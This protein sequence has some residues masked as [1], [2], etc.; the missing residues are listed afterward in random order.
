MPEREKS[1]SSLSPPSSVEL[2]GAIGGFRKLFS[3]PFGV[4]QTRNLD[5]DRMGVLL[6]TLH[7]QEIEAGSQEAKV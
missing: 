4:G 7:Q 1:V 5:I 6:A 2:R 3:S